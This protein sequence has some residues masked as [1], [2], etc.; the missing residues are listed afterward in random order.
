MILID[1]VNSLSIPSCLFVNNTNDLKEGVALCDIAAHI[2]N[3]V[4]FQNIFRDQRLPRLKAIH[5]LRVLLKE[6]KDIMPENLKSLTAEMIYQA[7]DKVYRLL[8]FFVRVLDMP[9]YKKLKAIFKN[10]SNQSLNI[11][12]LELPM[13]MPDVS[14]VK[15]FPKQSGGSEDLQINMSHKMIENPRDEKKTFEPLSFRGINLIEL[16]KELC[17]ID[18]HLND[19]EFINLCTSGILY[20]D[21]INSLE[22]REEKI[23]GINR[24]PKSSTDKSTNLLKVLKYLRNQPKMQSTYLWSEK[25]LLAGNIEIILGFVY[26]ILV[27]YQKIPK[28]NSQNIKVAKE[29]KPIQSLPHKAF[30]NPPKTARKSTREYPS[31]LVTNHYDPVLQSEPL[32]ITQEIID[33]TIDWLVSLDLGHLISTNSPQFNTDN[34]RNGVLLCELTSVIINKPKMTRFYHPKSINE[35]KENIEVAFSSLREIAHDV[36]MSFFYQSENIIKGD[37]NAI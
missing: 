16:L 20:A 3:K 6:I 29:F 13:S 26:Q 17:V 31:L 8:K 9:F 34:L 15:T 5:N 28:I 24:K 12:T 27:L 2:I 23:K 21:L 22:R 36:P 33:R 1:W 35:A 37:I 14:S 7:D 11:N 10:T 32:I 19:G 18:T 4:P 25:E 30:E